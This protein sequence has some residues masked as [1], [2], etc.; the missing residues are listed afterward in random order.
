MKRH[1]AML[2]ALVTTVGV[3]VPATQGLQAQTKPKAY[4]IAEYQVIGDQAALDAFGKVG[5]PLV[6]KAGGKLLNTVNGKD[7]S[8]NR[9]SS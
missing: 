9:G 1:I 3:S 4:S 8:T 6:E 2:L 7:H 5:I